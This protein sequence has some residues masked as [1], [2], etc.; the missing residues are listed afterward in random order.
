MI[1]KLENSQRNTLVYCA[2]FIFLFESFIK[3]INM[4]KVCFLESPNVISNPI[5]QM[6][7]CHTE[8]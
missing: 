3:Y 6:Q 8:I 5:A 2:Y 4:K 1:R 7:K